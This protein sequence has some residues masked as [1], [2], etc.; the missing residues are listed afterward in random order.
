MCL[1]GRREFLG[2]DEVVNWTR[3]HRCRLA[4]PESPRATLIISSASTTEECAS[5]P[6]PILVDGEPEDNSY[7]PESNTVPPNYA[8]SKISSILCDPPFLRRK[9]VIVDN[10]CDIAESAISQIDAFECFDRS[11]ILATEE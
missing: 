1:V 4:Q 2:G 5:H 9:I 3:S 11:G 6:K 7:P 8:G 10:L